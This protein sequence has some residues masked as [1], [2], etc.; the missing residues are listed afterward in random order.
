MDVIG[1]RRITG[2]LLL[3]IVFT[4]T[5][6][7]VCAPAEIRAAAN[8]HD[9]CHK[10]S[11]SSDRR[12]AQDC[13]SCSWSILRSAEPHGKTLI[14][15]PGTQVNTISAIFQAIAPI[16]SFVTILMPDQRPN[17]PPTLFGLHCQLLS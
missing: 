15:D 17:P 14:P 12:P 6:V 7:C 8:A 9:C 11:Q 13:P 2:S 5:V 1:L 4:A 16:Q 3:A 10:S